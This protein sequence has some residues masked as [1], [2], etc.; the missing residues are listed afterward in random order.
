MKIAT[1]N[2]FTPQIRTKSKQ[3]T[4]NLTQNNTSTN[5]L[6]VNNMHA[7]RDFNISFTG[8][9][10]E[11]FYPFN[12]DRMP[13]SMRNYLDYDYAQRQHMP[14]EQIMREVYKHLENAKTFDDVKRDYPKEDLFKGL[15]KPTIDSR[16]T[17]LAEIKTYR[18]LGTSPLL[19]DGSD[20]LGMY[21][22]KKIYIDG[23]TVKEINKDFH[24][25]DLSDEY[26]EYITEPID[27]NTTAAYGIKYP[28]R[29]F[30]I[31]FINTRDEYKKFFVTLPKDT[32]DPNSADRTSGNN[33]TLEKSE[34]PE[35][36]R[37][38][39]IYKTKQFRKDQIAKDILES[40]GDVKNIEKA[41]RKRYSKDDPEASFLIKYLSP[42][43]TVA[44]DKVHL[45]E[46]MKDFIEDEKING[47]Q[48]K[49]KTMFERFWKWTP[50]LK[51]HYSNAIKDT[52]ELFEDV[53]AGGGMLPINSDLDVITSNTEN[54]K[55]LDFVSPE[56]VD[57]IAYTKSIDP[58]RQE[59][60]AQHEELQKQWEQH[61]LERYGEVTQE[62]EETPAVE[63][64]V[65]TEPV[66]EAP[67]VIT[68]LD[69]LLQDASLKYNV[70][71]YRFKG[72]DDSVVIVTANLMEVFMNS[73]K[74]QSKYF[75]EKFA[76]LFNREMINNTAFDDNF[77]LS[78]AARQVRDQIEDGQILD[79][80][81][82]EST[83]LS[84][85]FNFYHKELNKTLAAGAAMCDIMLKGVN[86][87]DKDLGIIYRLMPAEL[88]LLL[89][90]TTYK[91]MADNL[92]RSKAELNRLYN[93]YSAPLSTNEMSKLQ[94][95]IMSEIQ[96]FDGNP[97]FMSSDVF[98]MVQMLKEAITSSKYKKEFFKNVALKHWLEERPAAKHILGKNISYSEHKKAKFEVLMNFLTKEML[99]GGLLP[100]VGKEIVDKHR[101]FLSPE[102]QEKI[103]LIES[104]LDPREV[105]LY[106]Q[107]DFKHLG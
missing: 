21:I 83:F 22:L 87:N 68:T 40:E 30:W 48:F 66:K 74:S 91:S 4:N 8:R 41:I 70:G 71:N 32:Y 49:G 24:E 76:T 2:Y 80:E 15:K 37:K 36:V 94:T 92:L 65:N 63:D 11:D 84:E 46:E 54:Q 56:F 95:T 96:N 101:K 6:K 19:K 25:K 86:I 17:V 57:L 12:R 53:Y 28:N 107:I 43:M 73:L 64:V 13:Y 106:E 81:Q 67:V 98:H 26:R 27:Y 9:T 79:D 42:I 59:K 29:H 3:N 14:P 61:F 23:K 16:K 44:A 103:A 77:I 102:I 62:L 5:S 105:I 45:S 89:R 99:P 47:K 78:V 104:S 50:A 52:I 60:Y 90:E 18:D 51:D 97:L 7:Y 75:P 100:V 34:K 1:I 20:D 35:E 82:I 33:K 39:R 88:D 55:I 93:Y 31:S 72:L 69:D 10:P 38:P 58:K 85:T